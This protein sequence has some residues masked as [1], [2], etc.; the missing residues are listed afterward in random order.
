M[1]LLL[2]APARIDLNLGFTKPRSQ[3]TAKERTE[4]H[5]AALARSGGDV[6]RAMDEILSVPH[7]SEG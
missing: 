3:M 4:L 7:K 1:S 6:H 2:S 5:K